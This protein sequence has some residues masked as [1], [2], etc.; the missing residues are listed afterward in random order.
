MDFRDSSDSS[1]G[2]I[3]ISLI[4]KE[5]RDFFSSLKYSHRALWLYGVALRL[6]FFSKFYNDVTIGVIEMQKR[7]NKRTIKRKIYKRL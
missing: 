1:H 5:I 7:L 3:S 4:S 6:R 2:K